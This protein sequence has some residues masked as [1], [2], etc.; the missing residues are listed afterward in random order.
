MIRCDKCMA[1][2][3]NGHVVVV[4]ELVYHTEC[5]PTTPVLEKVDKPVKVKRRRKKA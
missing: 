4:D 5:A 3:S 2:I 1:A